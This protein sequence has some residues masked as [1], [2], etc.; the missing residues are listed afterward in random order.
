MSEFFLLASGPDAVQNLSIFDPASPS[1]ES[2]RSLSLLV[3]AISAFIFIIVEGVLFY[4]V[5]RFRGRGG[6]QASEPPQVYGSK[7][8]EIAWT[9]APALIV[10]ILV[11]VVTRTLWAVN[12]PNP[13]PKPGDRALYVTV[14]GHQW[15]WE[16]VYDTYDGRKLGTVTANELHVPASGGGVVRPVY[17]TLKSADV[18]HSFWL[19]RLGGKTDLIPGHPNEMWFQT[20][21]PG[22]YLGQCAEYCGTQHANMLLRVMVDEPADFERWLENESEPAVAP[23][24]GDRAATG[25]QSTFLAQSC[26][27]CHRVRGTKADGKFGPDLTHLMARQTLASGMA[28]NDRETL[29]QWLADPQ[30]VKQGCLMP[31]FG[32][33]PHEIDEIVEYLLTLR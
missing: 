4:S 19:P 2:I 3:A 26:V 30:S 22:L 32:L 8:I 9:A 16:Y 20:D 24:A 10:F 6:P 25:A 23:A 17:L 7:A 15:W 14:I 13:E 33:S 21:K 31:A 27:N 12:R 18:C 28:T 1:A 29:R 11:L 5:A